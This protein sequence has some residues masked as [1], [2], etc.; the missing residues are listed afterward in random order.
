MSDKGKEK[1][2]Q[3]L[4]EGDSDKD[5]PPRRHFLKGIVALG[6]VAAVP[7]VHACSSDAKSSQS[8]G[9]IVF[10]LQARGT[11]HCNACA[12]HHK[13]KIFL[14]REFAD[15]GRA[16]IGCNCPIT[17]QEISNT[18]FRSLFENTGAIGIG[19]VDLRTI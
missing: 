4:V 1:K 12:S 2:T 7:L 18:E 14:T 10:R 6:A 8:S 9:V 17:T 11:K 15:K 13:F 16:H 19:S 3:V 5:T